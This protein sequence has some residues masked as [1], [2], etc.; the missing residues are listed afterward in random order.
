MKSWQE[1]T[2]W[3]ESLVLI[4]LESSESVS[5]QIPL[6]A[7]NKGCLFWNQVGHNIHALCGNGIIKVAS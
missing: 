6:S 5:K 4:S 1:K 7:L 2:N 3:V